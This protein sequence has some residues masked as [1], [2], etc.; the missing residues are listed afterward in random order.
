MESHISPASFDLDADIAVSDLGS[1]E[2]LTERLREHAALR[3]RREND[4]IAV[5]V[6]SERWR[7]IQETICDLEQQINQYE[8]AAVRTIINERNSTAN[9]APVTDRTWTEVTKRIKHAGL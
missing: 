5:L 4:V 8:D 3:L 9:F 7:E 1:E 2:T 6:S